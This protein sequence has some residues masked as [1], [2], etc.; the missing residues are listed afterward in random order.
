MPGVIN[1]KICDLAPECGGIEICPTGAFFWN[2]KTKKPDIDNSKCTSCGVCVRECPVDA[3]IVVQTE[4][5]FKKVL[6][7]IKNDPRSEKEL[8]RERLGTEPGRTPPKG[9]IITPTNFEKEVLK[10]KGLV[11]LDV[12]H[13]DY[14]DCRAY[15]VLFEDLI[16]SPKI[17]IKFAKLDAKKYPRLVKKLKVKKLPTLLLCLNGK[18]VGR[19]EGYIY[20]G[21][22]SKVRSLIKKTVS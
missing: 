4:E 17:K 22:K 10:A 11:A 12:W 18:E 1:Y 16:S 21:D 3:I 20:S 8:W 2:K 14:L 5:E 15:S 13:I 19:Y 6:E 9:K 7:D